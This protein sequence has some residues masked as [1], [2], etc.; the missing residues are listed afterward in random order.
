MA[1]AA[2]V[3]ESAADPDFKGTPPEMFRIGPYQHEFE[4]TSVQGWQHDGFPIYECCRG[5][6]GMVGRLYLYCDAGTWA[7]VQIDIPVA[8]AGDVVGLGAPAFRAAVA[9]ED[10]RQPGWHSWICYDSPTATWWPPSP[11]M[12]T[13]L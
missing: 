11:F 13:T 6:D 9:G 8:A 12:T 7:A 1:H 4:Y 3:P 10:V 2:F 5:R